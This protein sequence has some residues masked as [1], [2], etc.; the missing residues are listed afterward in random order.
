MNLILK[1]SDL[2]MLIALDSL[3]EVQALEMQ[4]DH[5]NDDALKK[6][7]SG[8][9]PLLDAASNN[10]NIHAMIFLPSCG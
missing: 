6:I 3:D 8:I 7:I 5:C 10:Q 4:K 2:T 9:K 1:K